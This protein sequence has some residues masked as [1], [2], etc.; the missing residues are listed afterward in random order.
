MSD[1]VVQQFQKRL[2]SPSLDSLVLHCVSHILL[3]VLDT[4]AF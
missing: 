3:F 4:L 2:H 1:L